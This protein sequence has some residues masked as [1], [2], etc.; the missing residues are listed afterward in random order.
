MPQ[1]VCT[2]AAGAWAERVLLE[3]TSAGSSGAA[4]GG[5]HPRRKKAVGVLVYAGSGP[6]PLRLAIQV[7]AAAGWVGGPHGTAEMERRCIEHHKR[8]AGRQ[9]SIPR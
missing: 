7:G 2:P 1:S 4:E 8:L 6:A 5:A 3:P 9:H